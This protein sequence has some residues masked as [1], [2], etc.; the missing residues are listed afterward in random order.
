MIDTLL[1]MLV[2]AAIWIAAVLQFAVARDRVITESRLSGSGRWL[3]VAGLCGLGARFVFLLAD[4]G[5][6]VRVPVESMLSILALSIG[7]AA[8]ALDRLAREPQRR[9]ST[10]AMGMQ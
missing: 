2:T 5:G 7:C 3:V 1:D 4:G 9:R 8:T 6:N 10:D